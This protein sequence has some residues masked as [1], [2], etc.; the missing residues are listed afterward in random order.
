MDI[1][2]GLN[3]K[4]P[5]TQ[6]AVTIGNFD[7]VH[8]GHKH[9]LHT[10]R[11][12]ANTRSLTTVAIIFE[13]QTA[14]FFAKKNHRTPPPRLSPL[15]DKLRLLKQTTDLD[16]V[17]VLPFTPSF[18]TQDANQ[19]IQKI[20]RQSLKTH[21]LLVGDDF[22]FGAERQG[23]FELLQTQTDFITERSSSIMIHGLRASSTA[24]RQALNN[25][26]IDV[27]TQML[28]HPYS[29]SGKVKHGAKL[30]R[31]IDT[32]TANVHLPNLN[33]ALHGVFVVNVH[34]DFGT[35]RGVASLGKNPT[36]SHTSTPKLEVHLFDFNDNLYA[37]RI[38]V[39]FLHKLRDEIHFPDW[40]SLKQQIWTD[41]EQAKNW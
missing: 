7:G 25:G 33:F 24:I 8:I 30:G 41:R 37:K 39:E 28:G 22:R 19:F 40:E 3:A 38:E 31:T 4:L 14:E 13:P 5:Y 34:G 10:L 2:F 11:K 26:Q 9:I 20:L 6:T 12:V 32:P 29:L 15:R 35:R 27:A 36:V 17:W 16:A 23:D 18:A 1:W 21:Y